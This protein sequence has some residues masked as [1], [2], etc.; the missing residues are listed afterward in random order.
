MK[1]IFIMD[2]KTKKEAAYSYDD[3]LYISM[4]AFFKDLE[5][6]GIVKIIGVI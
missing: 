2:D 4:L 1:K 6:K 3:L 5:S